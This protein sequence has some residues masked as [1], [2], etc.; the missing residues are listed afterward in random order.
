MS[1]QLQIVVVD[2][3]TQ[4]VRNTIHTLMFEGVS[5]DDVNYYMLVY[6]KSQGGNKVELPP[7][8]APAV[9]RA[10]SENKG[11][12]NL[13]L[14]YPNGIICIYEDVLQSSG[15]N[16]RKASLKKI[17]KS[18]YPSMMAPQ[19][20]DQRLL[21]MS[22]L[23]LISIEMSKFE[24]EIVQRRPMSCSDTLIIKIEDQISAYL[25]NNPNIGENT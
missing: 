22:G 14:I 5:R 21:F 15:R 8:G 18:D 20:I 16:R 2:R 7:A 6:S 3:T 25:K 9:D 24:T 17:L 19:I 12:N 10:E 13:L 11:L 4:T 23:S 1:T